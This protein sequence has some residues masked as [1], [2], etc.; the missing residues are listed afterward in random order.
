[1]RKKIDIIIFLSVV[2]IGIIIS[3][4]NNIKNNN[5]VKELTEINV[6]E[7]KDNKNLAIM[8]KG[9]S[10]EEY[11]QME[12]RDSWPEYPKYIYIKAEC[13]DGNGSKLVGT[14]VINYD[15]KTNKL[16]MTTK[17]TLYCTLYFAE[18]GD[19]YSLIVKQGGDTFKQAENDNTMHRFIGTYEEVL[20]N[21]I[22]FGTTNQGDCVQNP[23]EYMYR[24]IGVV[25]GENDL[26]LKVGQIKVIKATSIKGDDGNV[27]TMKWASSSN[28][29]YY[30]FT[31]D[32][33]DSTSD[34][35]AT[36]RYYLNNDFYNDLQEPWKSKITTQQWYKG[37]D[38]AAN[39]A[40][41]ITNERTSITNDTSNPNGYPIGL[42][43][44]SDYYNSW[45]YVGSSPYST[46]SWLNI[47]HGYK[48][49]SSSCSNQAEWT[50]TR[51]GYSYGN[52]LAW[53]VGTNGGLGGPALD[54]PHTVR[55]VF[56]LASN[57]KLTGQGNDIEP[58]II[59]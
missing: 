40:T 42:M 18:P 57:V 37:D 14:N 47:C 31:W 59:S 52:I 6:N 45:T 22:C 38:T 56:Y 36:L 30:N 39:S 17:T 19:A 49:G 26:N 23:D 5:E 46:D 7:L 51:F 33:S 34:K 13:D 21:Y 58:F 12:S 55:P 11:T 29:S 25:T 16:T 54:S 10:E 50:M 8:V 41:G 28:S 35:G 24:I 4:N 1:M 44:A 27:K 20:N 15:E 9:T 2:I 32:Y 48:T 43:Y 3:Y 53:Y